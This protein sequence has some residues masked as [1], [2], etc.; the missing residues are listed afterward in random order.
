MITILAI[1]IH[2]E[3]ERKRFSGFGMSK[4]GFLLTGKRRL[5]IGAERHFTTLGHRRAIRESVGVGLG[6]CRHCNG[7]LGV[8]TG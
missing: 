6:N 7:W 1:L 8:K 5:I 4:D 3:S 2:S